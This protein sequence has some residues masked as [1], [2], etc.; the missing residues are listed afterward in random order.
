M[1]HVAY[2]TICH[3]TICSHESIQEGIEI[4]KRKGIEPGRSRMFWT[5]MWCRTGLNPHVPLWPALDF[6]LSVMSCTATQVN[7]GP[8]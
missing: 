6:P 4:C 5:C 7:P 3:L 2:S 8:C 1:Q